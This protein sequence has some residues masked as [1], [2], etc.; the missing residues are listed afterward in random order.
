MG[1]KEFLDTYDKKLIIVGIECNH[2]GQKRLSEYCPYQIESKYFGH[3]NGQG[4]IL[5]DWVVNEL[6][7][8]VDQK[9]RTYPF[10]ECTGIAGSS[11]GGLMAFYTVIYYN[12]YFS[13]AACI[14]P[15]ISMCMEELKNEY[16]QAK[17]ME[18][19]RVYFS[20]GTD[21]VKGKNGIQWMLNNI[22]YF[23]DR[24]IESNASSYINVVEKGQHNE[25]SWQLEN[26]IYL[27]YLW[28]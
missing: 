12:K 15:S 2:E 13:K 14:S 5:M 17:I 24:L 7:I 23:N 21:E 25:A 4:K 3:L 28:K 10:R 20:F 19:T 18:D 26:Q 27:D 9:Y 8:L 22:L 6:K 1:L 11:M 16:T